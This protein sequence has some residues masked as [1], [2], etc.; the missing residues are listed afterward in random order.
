MAEGDDFSCDDDRLDYYIDHDD[1]DYGDETTPFIP[2][3]A[4][5]PAF[6]QYQARA[7][8]EM[9]MKTF[10]EKSGRPETSYAETSF[11]GTADLER[12]LAEL[13][14]DAI[15]GMLDTTKIPN[16]KNP[17]SY[18]E[19]EKE[20]QRVRDFIKK[21]YPNAD[22]SKLVIRFSSTTPMDIV[23][24]GKGGSETKIIKD[25]G[26]DFQKSFSNL[27]YVKNAFGESFEQIQKNA[28]QELIKERKNWPIWKKILLK[29]RSLSMI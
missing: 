29:I 4:S 21:R 8:Q 6:G 7:Q 12:R 17:L 2:N 24:L 16:L 19:R 27:T 18:E 11:G 10:Q 9:E 5:T 3:G 1:Y 28:N 25:N 15:T 23:V 13:R 14:R 22:F 26:S 20:I